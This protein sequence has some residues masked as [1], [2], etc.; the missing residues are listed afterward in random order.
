MFEP[1]R[2]ENNSPAYVPPQPVQPPARPRPKVNWKVVAL[3]VAGFLAAV[4]VLFVAAW[5]IG[6]RSAD[7]AQDVSIWNCSDDGGRYAEVSY[8]VTN[9]SN[10]TRDYRITVQVRD[11]FGKRVGDTTAVVRDVAPGDTVRDDVT[12]TIAGNGETCEITGVR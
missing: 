1:P 6:D 9:S 3:S 4:A 2:R 12:L 11:V 7:K 5:L 10:S 8:Q